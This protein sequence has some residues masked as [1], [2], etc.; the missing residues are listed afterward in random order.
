MRHLVRLLRG[1]LRLAA[2]DG[3]ELQTVLLAPFPCGTSPCIDPIFG[4]TAADD[5]WSSTTDITFPDTAWGVDF[6]VGVASS[7]SKDSFRR[8]R[9][10]RGGL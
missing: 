3:R 10:V 8:V 9:A 7:A 5:Y 6:N 1:P 4:P 2:A